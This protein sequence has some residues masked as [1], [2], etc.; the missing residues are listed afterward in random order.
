LITISLLKRLPLSACSAV[1]HRKTEKKIKQ[2]SG[3]KSHQDRS[4]A[5]GD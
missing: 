4:R 2:D 3:Y 5:V 1:I